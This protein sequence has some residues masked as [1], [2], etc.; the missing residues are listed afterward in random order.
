MSEMERQFRLANKLLRQ[1]AV[2]RVNRAAYRL[3]ALT[4]GAIRRN[5]RVRRASWIKGVAVYPATRDRPAALVR[6]GSL[7]SVFA[8]RRKRL[9]NMVVL[10][11]GGK[12]LGFERASQRLPWP[13]IWQRIKDR[14]FVTRGGV[15]V[16]RTLQGEQVPIYKFQTEVE[17]SKRI[18]FLELGEKVRN[19]EG[20]NE[21]KS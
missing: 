8:R 14:S 11:S 7:Q 2:E 3:Q 1:K 4:Q 16:Y 5:F 17:T 12:K 6:L 15:V 13:K 21:S 10:L 20:F 9:G 19:Q 18:P